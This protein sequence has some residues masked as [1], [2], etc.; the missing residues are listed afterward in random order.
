VT[1]TVCFT[2]YQVT[3]S[4][5]ESDM[6]DGGFSSC[7]SI[8]QQF[9]KLVDTGDRCCVIFAEM[10]VASRLASH[11]HPDLIFPARSCPAALFVSAV[12]IGL[13]LR[14]YCVILK[15]SVNLFFFDEWDIYAP[16]FEHAHWWKIFVSQH[17]PHREGVGVVVVSW[18]L[19]LTHWNSMPQAFAIGTAIALAMVLAIRLKLRVFGQLIIADALIPAMFLGLG[20]WEVLV[21][22]P[23]PGRMLRFFSLAGC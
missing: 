9:C 2:N 17:G 21:S 15:Y 8:Q 19:T 1:E 14:F 20:Q 12:A 6:R 13:P 23:Q 10:S 3:S 22:G 18:L 5:F 11:A 7:V 4:A 16:L